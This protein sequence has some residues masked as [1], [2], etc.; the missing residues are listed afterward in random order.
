MPSDAG[1][2]TVEAQV[3]ELRRSIRALESSARL[4]DP[5]VEQREELWSA[6]GGIFASSSRTRAAMLR[7]GRI[8]RSSRRRSR[9]ASR[10][11]RTAICVFAW[12]GG[13]AEVRA[14][15]RGRWNG[16]DLTDRLLARDPRRP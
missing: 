13:R 4:L 7:T 12:D 1:A 15:A 14:L 9:S 8:R 2:R 3:S 10:A 6:V 11:N 16:V 5:D